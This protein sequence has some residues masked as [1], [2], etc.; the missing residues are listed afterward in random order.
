MFFATTGKL[1]ASCAAHVTALLTFA[2]LTAR[3][4]VGG[5]IAHPQLHHF[6]Y[7][8]G[9]DQGLALIGC[10]AK[11][12]QSAEQSAI[13]TPTNTLLA[14]AQR[15]CGRG[16]T[17]F[18]ISDFSRWDESLT[19]L[20]LQLG[21]QR[22]LN[23]IQIIDRGEQSLPAIGKLRLRSPYS[24][25]TVII[26]SS[27]PTLRQQYSAVMLAQQPQIESLLQRCGVRHICLHTDDNLVQT[28][29]KSL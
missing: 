18:I 13:F 10:V 8:S 14:E 28:L 20:L 21:E 3:G 25:T 17:L 15:L 16:D 2:V 19:A 27:N 4:E 29:A 1:K 22:Q 23:A 26:D 12:E 7:S 24:G 11:A 9:L 5:V 6:G